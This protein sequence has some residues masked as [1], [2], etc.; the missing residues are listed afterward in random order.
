MLLWI[1][2]GGIPKLAMHIKVWRC[3]NVLYGSW[4][5]PFYPSWGISGYIMSYHDLMPLL[6]CFPHSHV[7]LDIPWWNPEAGHAH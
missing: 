7:A 5:C 4:G 2:H 1:S 3:G 6:S